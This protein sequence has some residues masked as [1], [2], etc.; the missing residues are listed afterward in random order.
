[1]AVARDQSSSRLGIATAAVLAAYS[2][3]PAVVQASS[4]ML[5]WSFAGAVGVFFGWYPARRAAS[6]KPVDALR[7]E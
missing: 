4:V 1:M 2:P 7:Y 6:M 3:Y 5:G